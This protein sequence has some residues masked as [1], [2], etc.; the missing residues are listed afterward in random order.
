MFCVRSCRQLEML[1]GDMFLA[2]SFV[3][4]LGP[5][6]GSYRKE[7]LARWYTR[8]LQLGI[9]CTDKFS[10]AKVLVDPVQV[11]GRAL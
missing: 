3:S 10:L 8:A 4:Y 11:G 9:V 7:L 5:L 2:S 6:T 1:V